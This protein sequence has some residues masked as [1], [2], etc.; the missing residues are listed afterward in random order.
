MIIDEADE[1]LHSDWE[2]DLKQIMEGGGMFIMS[3]L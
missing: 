1:M 2:Q 3:H